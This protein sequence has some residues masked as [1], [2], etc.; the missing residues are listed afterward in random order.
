MNCCLFDMKSV[1]SGGFTMGNLDY[2]EPKTLD[3]AFDLIADVAIN[4]AACQ[5]GGFTIS[6]VDK[7]LAPYAE[8]S[9]DFYLKEYYD[10]KPSATYEEADEWAFNKTKREA[11][12]GFQGWEMKFN[13]VASFGVMFKYLATLFTCLCGTFPVRLHW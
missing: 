6:E 9:Y 1:L 5:Y 2:Q 4:A 8:K 10:I 11:E 13:S 12:Q 3:V 7:L